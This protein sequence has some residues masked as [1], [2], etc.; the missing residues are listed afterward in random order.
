LMGRKNRMARRL[1]RGQRLGLLLL[2]ALGLFAGLGPLFSPFSLERTDLAGAYLPP[3]VGGH[4]LGTDL[5]GR[6]VLTLLA[7]ALGVSLAVALCAVAVQVL[8]GVLLGLASGCLGRAVDRCIMAAVDMVLSLPTLLV[9]LLVSALLGKLELGAFARTGLV[10][11]VIGLLSWPACARLVRGETLRLR[12][13]GFITAAAAGGVTAG[14]ILTRY[15][16]PNLLPQ[17]AVTATLGIGDAII[18]ESVLSFLGLGVSPPLVSLGGM[19]RAMARLA[20][21]RSRPWLWLGAGLLVI[22]CVAAFHLIG[23]GLEEGKRC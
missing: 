17:V 8:L 12:E 3:L 6:D 5:A 11:V 19:I 18:A 23:A 21:L 2:G 20:D 15:L 22:L 4:L 14:R 13:Q 7:S 16:L 10:A 9:L 1:A